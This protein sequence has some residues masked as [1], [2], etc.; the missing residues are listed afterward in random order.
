[1]VVSAQEEFAHCPRSCLE[2]TESQEGL[3]EL[4]EKQQERSEERAWKKKQEQSAGTRGS[5]PA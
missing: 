2:W 4:V 1:M 3:P 5:L